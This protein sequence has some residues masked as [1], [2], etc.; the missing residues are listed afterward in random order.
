MDTFLLNTRFSRHHSNPYSYTKKVG[1]H[2]I[3]LVIYVDDLILTSSETKLLN[4]VKSNLKKE[5]EMIDLGHMSYFL[6]FY[7]SQF[8]EEIS[9]S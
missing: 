6:S 8:K 5:F 7:I 2:L 4:R 9:L 1:D 3:I